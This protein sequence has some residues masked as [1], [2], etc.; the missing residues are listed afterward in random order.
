MPARV[1][2]QCPNCRAFVTYGQPGCGAC[3]T[4]FLVPVAPGSP[5]PACAWHPDVRSLQPCARCGSFACA[6]CLRE[7]DDAA[8]CHACF[9]REPQGLTPWDRRAELGFFKAYFLTAWATISR[10]APFFRKARSEGSF[11][12]SFLFALVSNV[13]AFTPTMLLYL[14]FFLAL[15]GFLERAAADGTEDAPKQDFFAIF[16]GI[17]AGYAVVLPFLGVAFTLFVAG[18]DHLVMRIAG[19]PGSFGV[20]FRAAS[21]SLG[22]LIVGVIPLCGMYVYP[23]WTVVL[24]MFAYQGLHR[25]TMAKGAWGAWVS[26]ALC[27]LSC[28][29]WYAAMFA[30]GFAQGQGD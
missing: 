14:L 20:T 5:D 9:D 24:K 2:L 28:V 25:T 19:V 13:L 8:L 3:G 27:G 7:G 11:G 17:M 10:P 6:Q 18:I 23:L 15:P 21:L 30:L 16:Y 4:S 22:P 26:F 1:K 29:G 12:S